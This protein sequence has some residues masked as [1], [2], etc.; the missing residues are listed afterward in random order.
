MIGQYSKVA[1]EE[2]IVFAKKCHQVQT[3]RASDEFIA[4]S[5]LRALDV[6]EA[7]LLTA[8]KG[9]GAFVLMTGDKRCLT[10]LADG[11]GIDEIQERLK[12]RVI[13]LEQV[14]LLLIRRSRFEFIKQQVLS[15]LE[16]D[17]AIGACFGSGELATE[18]N[19]VLALE[20]YIEDLKQDAPGLLADISQF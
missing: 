8:T 20:G 1:R 10:A 7:T 13:C 19:V 2:A 14:I 11:S 12:G 15:S 17:K 6:G 16:I 9:M 5:Q 4:L 18:T 3:D